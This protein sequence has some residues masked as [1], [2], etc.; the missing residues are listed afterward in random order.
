[1]TKKHLILTAVAALTLVGCVEEGYNG[2][3]GYLTNE[4]AI[5][6]AGGTNATT[7]ALLSGK[8]AADKL[9]GN[10]VVYG[11][12]T[13]DAGKQTVYDHYTVKYVEGTSHS[14]VTNLYGWEYVG[15]PKNVLSNITGAQTIKYWDFGATQYDFIA[16]STGTAVQTND[17]GQVG[18][19]KILLSQVDNTPKYTIKGTTQD[20]AKV[21]ISDRVSAESSPAQRIP[22]RLVAYRD[23]VQFNFRS[24]SSKTRL[25]LY[26]LIPGYS[27]KNVRFY[28]AADTTAPTATAPTLFAPDA[29]IPGGTGVMT[30]TFPTVDKSSADYNK[31]HASFSEGTNTADLT[32]TA[33]T[34][35]GRDKLEADETVYLGRT[36]ADASLCAYQTT[37]PAQVGGLT[38]KVDYTLVSRDGSGETIEVKGAT[39]CVPEQYCRW[40]P[41]N[42]Y[43]YLF[44]ITDN[45]NGNIGAITGLYPIT[46]DAIVT[47]TE[48]GEQNTVTTISLPSI[49]TYSKGELTNALEYKKGSTIY[50]VVDNGT[51]LTI[52]TDAKLFTVTQEDTDNTHASPSETITESTVAMCISQGNSVKDANG[53]T[54]TVTAASGL[55][56]FS[57]IP[58]NEAPYG[59]ALTI[60]G[61]KFT[62]ETAGTYAFEYL[63]PAVSAVYAP[64]A[65]GTDLTDGE[66]YY[67]SSTGEGLFVSDGTQTNVAADTYWTLVTPA[68]EAKKY[69][70]IIKV[71]D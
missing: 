48:D 52:D 17:A 41:N 34:L 49:T 13:K 18:E 37:L 2:I 42:A 47:T 9:G 58:A 25:G 38:L 27:V 54:M 16:F 28:K 46:F 31:A 67:T 68:S 50:V 30:V 21:F 15:Q 60:D 26:E 20:L 36:S 1:M 33:I 23:A 62:P 64:V 66:T 69:Y 10:F 6:F 63:A 11:F 43:T 12:K 32:L 39:A 14:T 22:N 35:K 45:T 53:W 3:D 70:K 51:K 8:E 65:A 4:T 71:I 24:L 56:D 59:V 61:A 19:G 29:N 5:S 57:S 55:K 7:R 40:E 44:K